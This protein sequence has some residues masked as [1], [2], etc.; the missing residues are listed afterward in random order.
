MRRAGAAGADPRG[1]RRLL[2][3]AARA[4]ARPTRVTVVFQTRSRRS[5]SRPTSP[6][7]LARVARGGRAPTAGRSAGSQS[8]RCDE[9]TGP[10]EEGFELELRVW[11][12]PSRLAALRRLPRQLARL[13]AV[14]LSAGDHLARQ[15]D[16][17]ARPQAP[18]AAASTAT[19]PD[20]SPSRERIS[21]TPLRSAGIEP[22]H[23]LVA[24]ET[25]ES[26]ARWS[27]S[28]RCRT[29]PARSA[30][31]AAPTCRPSSARRAS[32]SGSSPTRE[33]RDADPHRRRLRRE[34]R[35]VRRAAPTRR[36]RRRFAPPPARSS[37]SRSSPGTSSPG[38]GSRSSPTAASRSARS[39]SSPPVTFLLGAERAGLPAELVAEGHEASR[40]RCRARPSP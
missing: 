6:R 17:E 4:S 11:P 10:P 7:R 13:A 8:R 30:S 19:R 15:R 36:R 32:G 39:T 5:T 27:V 38:G 28:R 40:S 1:L 18:R 26:R 14:R 3:G 20:S 25:I 9:R 31:T 29:R 16:A 37:A 22:V 24:G 34:R 35:A 33:R 2:P 23:L 21:S 12:A